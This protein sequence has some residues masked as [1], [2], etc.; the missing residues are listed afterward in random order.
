[1]PRSFDELIA[2]AEEL[3]DKLE[4]YEPHDDDRGEP[5]LMAVRRIAY[6][7]SLLERCHCP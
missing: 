2:R 7:R 5:P 6:Q 1:M 4:T 3:A